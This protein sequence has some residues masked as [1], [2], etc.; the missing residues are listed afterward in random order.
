MSDAS[1]SSYGI[2]FVFN[3]LWLE[4]VASPVAGA[5]RLLDGAA[6]GCVLTHDNAGFT[7][8]W[9]HEFEETFISSRCLSANANE[10]KKNGALSRLRR[11]PE[12]GA[13]LR[14]CAR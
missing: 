2:P 9:G 3:C 11:V 5:R 10:I 4:I 12:R 7:R 8:H 1:R 14:D 6:F 13:G